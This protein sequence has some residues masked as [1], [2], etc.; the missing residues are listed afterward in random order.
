MKLLTDAKLAIQVLLGTIR[1]PDE[2]TPLEKQE[3]YKSCDDIVE[4]IE[5]TEK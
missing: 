1:H 2:C 3:I 4:A 5:E